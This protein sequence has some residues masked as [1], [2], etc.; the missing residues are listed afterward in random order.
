LVGVVMGSNTQL[1]GGD[2]DHDHDHGAPPE[3]CVLEPA[4]KRYLG[5]IFMFRASNHY[6]T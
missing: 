2:H 5:V 1:S 6:I 4:M 3:S